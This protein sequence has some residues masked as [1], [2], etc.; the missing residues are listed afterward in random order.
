MTKESGKYGFQDFSPCG[1]R[2]NLEG[3]VDT[4]YQLTLYDMKGK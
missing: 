4:E 3:R 2:K 1:T